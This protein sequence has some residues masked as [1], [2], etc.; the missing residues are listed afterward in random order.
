MI[1]VS[2]RAKSRRY[3]VC[4]EE[5]DLTLHS[6]RYA[7]NV[8]LRDGITDASYKDIFESVSLSYVHRDCVLLSIF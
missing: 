6:P 4:L 8:P 5:R 7:V 3:E 1:L 2:A